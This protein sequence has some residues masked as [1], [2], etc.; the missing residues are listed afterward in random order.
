MPPL[1]ESVWSRTELK[2]LLGSEYDRITNMTWLLVDEDAAPPTEKRCPSDPVSLAKLGHFAAF[3]EVDVHKEVRLGHPGVT[4]HGVGAI[5]LP[6]RQEQAQE[7]MAQARQAPHG[8]GAETVIDTAVRNTWELDLDQ[9]SLEEQ[10]SALTTRR[11]WNSVLT[12]VKANAMESLGTTSSTCPQGNTNKPNMP[13]LTDSDQD[14]RLRINI[15][16]LVNTLLRAN[17]GSQ[18]TQGSPSY[19][20]GSRPPPND[21]VWEAI[22]KKKFDTKIYD[23]AATNGNGRVGGGAGREKEVDNSMGADMAEVATELRLEAKY[24]PGGQEKKN[25]TVFICITGDR[26]MMQPI[27]KV[28][29][30]GIHLELWAWK[31]GISKEYLKLQGGEGQHPLFCVRFLDWIFGEISFTNF[32]ST[33]R[34]NR[35]ES[36]KAV[37]LTNFV[38][39]WYEL[40]EEHGCVFSTKGNGITDE[41]HASG[42]GGLS[43]KTIG[44]IEKAVCDHIMLLG[45][46]FYISPDTK[47]GAYVLIAEFPNVKDIEVVLIRLQRD[48]RGKA[49]VLSWPEY[50]A[51]SNRT[52]PPTETTKNMYAPLSD[53]AS[54]Q[55]I[56]VEDEDGNEYDG[57][58]PDPDPEQEEGIADKKGD[59]SA[60]GVQEV[61]DV[62]DA[63]TWQTVTRSNP[64]AAHRRAHNHKQDCPAGIRCRARGECGKQHS[65]QERSLFQE[66]P[67]RNFKLWKTEP[68]RFQ[69]TRTGC[70]RGWRC[71]YAHSA[72]VAWCLECQCH[73]HY[74][75]TCVYRK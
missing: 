67:N 31:S 27:K 66:F 36:S 47:H 46:V 10:T 7:I 70:S 45:K 44:H 54:V 1:T 42:G 37:V 8:R 39:G 73:G 58:D 19:L 15:G 13:K 28:L 56:E 18:R 3:D 41:S 59:A 4:V 74:T 29:D 40:A 52:T 60:V 51:Q 71:A 69:G 17:D 12:A 64:G 75:S 11:E 62:E 2:L 22:R 53:N 50:A 63:G 24:R 6:L 32:Y 23:K 43:R 72:R 9:F 49:T 30:A 5:D 65:S 16:R 35:I 25:R 33:R 34:G 20:Y 48:F 26:D 57:E 55:E 14:P 61:E 21:A 68:C 38:P